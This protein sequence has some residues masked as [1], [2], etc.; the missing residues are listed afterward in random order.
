MEI[1]FAVLVDDDIPDGCL[2]YPLLPETRCLIKLDKIELS[3]IE[4]FIPKTR[5]PN[6][7]ATDRAS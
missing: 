3:P 4:G 6:L 1:Q 2:V 5:S 7:I